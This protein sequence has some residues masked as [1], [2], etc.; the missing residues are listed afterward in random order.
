MLHLC[1]MSDFENL[2]NFAYP[3][4]LEIP[5]QKKHISLIFHK[6]KLLSI[7]RNCFK[8]HPKAKEI[9]YPYEEMH[10]ELDA[11]RKLPHKYRGLKL[12]LVNVRYNRFRQLRMSRPCELC[13]PWCLEVFDD[14]YY[15]DNEGIKRM[16]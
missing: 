3:L 1:F 9:G 4:C 16:E 6:K 12:T 11:Y 10:S 15:T 7:G 5:R 2:L 14:I 8:T 13:T